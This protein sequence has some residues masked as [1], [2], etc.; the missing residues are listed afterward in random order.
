MSSDLA[1]PGAVVRD[2]GATRL[3]QGYAAMAL[4][5]VVWAGFALSAR[6]TS[7]S[8]LAFADVAMIRALV[9]TLIFLPFLPSRWSMIRRAGPVACTTIA[10]GAGLPFFWLAATG[11]AATS[12]AHVGALIA[13][14][15]PISAAILTTI[16]SRR[17]PSAA[18]SMA[19]G[20][21]LLGAVLLIVAQPHSG[22]GTAKGIGL[23]LMASVSWAAYTLALKTARMDPIAC[24]I[25]IAIPSTLAMAVLM[26]LGLAPSHFGQFTFQDALPFIA[27]QGVGVGVIASLTY[28]FAISRIG[29]AQ[30]AAL[31]SLAPALTAVIAVPLLHETLTPLML[32]AILTICMGVFLASRR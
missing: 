13:G 27:A 2:E 10:V 30:S 26:G 20:L 24:G 25:T 19:L 3:L 5:V 11:G 14:T 17:L 28:A 32:L 9:P 15:V 4:T 8:P 22:A 29:A 23:L 31:G 1:E 18:S 16:I 6:A 12:A 7:G 21:I